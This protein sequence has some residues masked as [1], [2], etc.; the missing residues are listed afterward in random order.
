MRKLEYDREKT[1]GYAK[2]WAYDRNPK[3]YNFDNIRRRLHK[4]YI[5]MYICRF[6][7]YEL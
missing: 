1:I 4:F 2:K 5:T 6:K 3:Y 7:Y